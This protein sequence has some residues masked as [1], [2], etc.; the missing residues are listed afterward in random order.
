MA[1]DDFTRSWGVCQIAPGIN[2]VGMTILIGWRLRR[3]MGVALTMFGLLFPSVSITILMTALY[4]HFREMEVVRAAFEGI[5]P[6]TVGLGLLLAWR[7]AR[8][9]LKESRLESRTSL[10]LSLGLLAG[11]GTLVTLTSVPVVAV[12]WS[13]G[14]V[15]GLAAW[16]RQRL[17]RTEEQPR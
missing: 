15:A 11:S 4:H 12:L 5:V 1:A 16:R 8:P 2:L 10:S 13:T 6:G 7:M 14:L 3:A 17:A 9:L